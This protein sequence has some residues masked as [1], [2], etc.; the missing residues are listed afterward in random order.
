MVEVKLNSDEIFVLEKLLDVEIGATSVEIKKDPKNGLE[1]NRQ[2][3]FK[4]YYNVLVGL[5]E[6]LKND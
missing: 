2:R 4:N 5:K 1:K 6:K 3:E